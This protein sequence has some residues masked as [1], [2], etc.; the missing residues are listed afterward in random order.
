LTN[1]T[2]PALPL[3]PDSTWALSTT[4]SP[5]SSAICL[6]SP[7]VDANLPCGMGIPCLEK[8]SFAWYS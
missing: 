5:I 1:L 6:A 7:G 3:P 4:G 8:M 2:P